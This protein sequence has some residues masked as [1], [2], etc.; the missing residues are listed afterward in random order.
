MREEIREYLIAA[1]LKGEISP[2]A[3][4]VETRLANQFGVSQAP[5]REALRDLEMLGFIVSSPFRGTQVRRINN[6]E[7]ADIYPIRAAVEALAARAA[8]TQI[9]EPTLARLESLLGLMC[10][11]AARGDMRAEVDADIAFHHTIVVASGNRTLMQFWEMM[12]LET[13]TFLTLAV[14]QRPLEELAGRHRS[15]LA[16]LQARDPE[17]A[18]EAMRRHIEEPGEWIRAVADQEEQA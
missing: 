2:G 17:Q 9:D 12:R 7:L 11:A 8:A 4:I 1:I 14:T 3:K 13:T 10:D 5:V 18:A 15:V 6:R 16:A